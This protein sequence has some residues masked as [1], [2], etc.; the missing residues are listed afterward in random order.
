MLSPLCIDPPKGTK[1]YQSLHKKHFKPEVWEYTADG[2]KSYI[3]SKAKRTVPKI[4]N[5]KLIMPHYHERTHYKS[6]F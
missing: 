4:K 1:I 5:S 3:D 6:V 2:Y